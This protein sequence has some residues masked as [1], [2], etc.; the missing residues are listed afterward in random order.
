[1]AKRRLKSID[2]GAAVYKVS[3]VERLL[4]DDANEKLRGQISHTE[5]LVKLEESLDPQDQFITTIHECL[6]YYISQYGHSDAINPARLEGVINTLAV[7][8]T[9]LLRRNPTIITMLQEL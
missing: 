7:G 4:G 1:M 3:Y 6:H 9:A 5:C 2:F 8:M